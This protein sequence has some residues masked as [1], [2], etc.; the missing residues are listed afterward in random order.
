MSTAV[1]CSAFPRKREPNLKRSGDGCRSPSP[2]DLL[3]GGVL[4]EQTEYFTKSRCRICDTAVASCPRR[5]AQAFQ[6]H[7]DDPGPGYRS[8]LPS[9][10]QRAGEG[11]HGT[12]MGVPGRRPGPSIRACVLS[13][14]ISIGVPLRPG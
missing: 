6:H 10:S 13:A 9:V 8:R 11:Y 4:A 5:S 1:S 3:A 12:A 7:G 2:R 14:P